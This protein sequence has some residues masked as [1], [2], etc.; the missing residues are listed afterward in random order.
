MKSG[1]IPILTT[2]G[3][4]LPEAWEKSVLL[5]WDRGVQIATEYDRPSDPLSR[6]CTMIVTVEEPLTEPRIHRA[7]PADLETLEVYR[8]EVVFGVHDHYV[9]DHGWSYSYH[10]RLFNYPPG[11]DQIDLLVEKLAE[12]PHSRR[13]QAITWIPTT[14]ALIHEPP[15]LQRVWCRLLPN[16]DG[17]LILNMNTHWRSRDAF[18]AAFMNMFALTDLQHWVAEQ[19]AAQRGKRVLV[20][21]YVD[22]SDSYHIYGKDWEE[23]ERFQA[24]VRGRSFEER[25]WTTAFAEPFFER[26]RRQ[27]REELTQVS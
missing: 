3:R 8:Q 17:T 22:I 12:V 10:D 9:G 24:L 14:D 25:T 19:I 13:A 16:E 23:F 7:F 27:L 1:N 5:L 6:D 26:A 4:T 15:C 2:C 21:R 18:H 11:V 20:G